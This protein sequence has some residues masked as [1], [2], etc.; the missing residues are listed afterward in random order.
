MREKIGKNR[1][2]FI[3]M[4]ISFGIIAAV[5][6]S[7]FLSFSNVEDILVEQ[8]Q[9]NQL[10]KTQHATNQIESH[11]AEL[12]EELVTF[13][14]F[15]SMETLDIQ[16]CTG[17]MRAVHENVESKI[18]SLLR[19]DT[20]GDV[21]ECSSPRFSSYVGLNVKNKDY[22][23]VPKETGEPY[24]AGFER[25]GTNKQIIVSVPLFETTE[26]TPYPNFEGEFKGILLG[27]VELN[28]LHDKYILPV[29]AAGKS[30]F[31][32]FSLDTEETILK[33]DDLD[34]Y[35]GMKEVLPKAV[36]G[37]NTITDINGSGQ[38]I[39]TSSDL[40]IGDDTWRL[41]VLTPLDNV[42]KKILS[43]KQRNLLSF[44]LVIIVTAASFVIAISL[45]KSKE[46]AKSKLDTLG[47]PVESK[48][49]DLDKTNIELSEIEMNILEFINSSNE[50]NRLVT[51]KDIT[52]KFNITKPTTRSKIKRLHGLG[53]L[54]V[55]QQGRFKSLNITTVGKNIIS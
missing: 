1:K 16:Q 30:S 50:T 17:E 6:A 5:I 10:I 48:N 46:K 55:E 24:V 25:Q 36:T 26:Y 37:I 13:S 22:F 20:Q 12:S 11:V 31:L 43:A 49:E 39:I 4:I 3:V 44:L 41:I 35:I 9:E 14:K 27:I 2:L 40:A 51:Y 53:L 42:G 28:S 32:L 21:V 18:N 23:K 29:I 54:T 8:L 34:D 7:N 45:Y 47:V 19:V 33:S 15:P 38:T 52:K